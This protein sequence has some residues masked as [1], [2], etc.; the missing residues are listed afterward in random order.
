MKGQHRIS[1]P[2]AEIIRNLVDSK[3]DT[4]YV[5]RADGS[6]SYV[7]LTDDEIDA[8]L[9]VACLIDD[10]NVKFAINPR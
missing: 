9:W 3:L 6:P 4:A 5:N 1:H 8:L 7:L 10:I 2:N